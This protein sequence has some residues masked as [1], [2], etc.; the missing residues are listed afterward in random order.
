MESIFDSSS[1]INA[2]ELAEKI[3]KTFKKY[4]VKK[5]AMLWSLL[6]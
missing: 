5:I 2:A 3:E 6:E 1:K 4:K